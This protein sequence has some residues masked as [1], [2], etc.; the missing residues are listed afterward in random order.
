MLKEKV[1]KLIDD[2]AI[3]LNAQN[4]DFAIYVASRISLLNDYIEKKIELSETHIDEILSELVGH[5][6]TCLH[7]PLN[8]GIK[9]L[10]ARTYNTNYRET[11]ISQLSYIKDSTK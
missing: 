11:D 5:F 3:E 4:D 6:T 1:K 2:K 7:L 10:R 8:S 9:F